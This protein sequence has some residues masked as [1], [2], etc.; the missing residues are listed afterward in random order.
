M[1]KKTGMKVARKKTEAIWQADADALGWDLIERVDGTW[2]SYRHRTK[3]NGSPCG[4]EQTIVATT[5]RKG[6]CRC[7]ECESA[8]ARWRAEAEARGWGLLEQLDGNRGRYQHILNAAGAAC[9]HEQ[10]LFADKVRKGSVRCG[11][12]EDHLIRWRNEADAAGWDFV[13]KLDGHSANYQHRLKPDGV[14]CGHQ[15]VLQAVHIRLGSARCGGCQTQ[16]SRWRSAALAVGWELLEVLEGLR[17]KYRHRTSPNGSPCGHEQEVAAQAMRKG[18]VRCKRC[19]PEK[20]SAA[21]GLEPG[22]RETPSRRGTHSID[23]KWCAEADAQGWEFLNQLTGAKASYRHRTRR[24]GTLCGHVQDCQAANMRLGSVRCGGCESA[25][26]GWSHDADANGWQLV[27]QVDSSSYALF[28]HRQRADNAVCGHEQ[29][30]HVGAM[31][32]KQVRCGNCESHLIGWRLDA[33]QQGW[34][35]LAQMDKSH[36]IYGHRAKADGSPC[37]HEQILVASNMRDGHVRCEGCESPLI[38]WRRHADERGWDLLEQTGVSRGSF[39]HRLKPDGSSCGHVQEV[40]PGAMRRGDVRCGGCGDANVSA[41]HQ[42]VRAHL[43]TKACATLEVSTEVRLGLKPSM[44][45]D[46]NDGVARVDFLVVSALGRLIIEVDGAQHFLAAFTGDDKDLRHQ[47]FRDAFVEGEA[48][49]DGDLVLRFHSKE[50]HAGVLAAIDAAMAGQRTDHR[51][52]EHMGLMPSDFH[53]E[54][55]VWR[56]E[57]K[58]AY[59]HRVGFPWGSTR[60]AE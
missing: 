50:V 30:I 10:I 29:V 32:S 57:A 55:W 20:R 1:P 27:E 60:I 38:G 58:C 53:K 43:M 14:P 24:D 9:G 42:A 44:L 21:T 3:P 59:A 40:D 51:L 2:G 23:A 48:M 34:D 45:P 25:L 7:G 4:H 56:E 15:Q 19:G 33:E 47:I 49:A 41:L 37:G 39:R 26:I 35:L 22:Q 46:G 28:R 17:G 54:F 12:C 52:V 16:L 8:V 11:G 18:A 13:E 6:S 5:M 31:R 36:A